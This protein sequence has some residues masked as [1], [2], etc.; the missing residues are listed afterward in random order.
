M[1]CHS[2]IPQT[3][4]HT[5]PVTMTSP[6]ASPSVIRIF[7]DTKSSPTLRYTQP[8]PENVQ[9]YD[10]DPRLVQELTELR[11]LVKELRAQLNAKPVAQPVE[12]V[13]SVLTDVLADMCDN[14]AARVEKDMDTFN[15]QSF[16]KIAIND[17]WEME[18]FRKNYG[19]F[20]PK[21]RTY[22]H[23]RIAPVVKKHVAKVQWRKDEPLRQKAREAQRIRNE[24]EEAERKAR[25][26]L[27]CPDAMH[28]MLNGLERE[29]HKID[30]LCDN[31]HVKEHFKGVVVLE[32]KV[33]GVKTRIEKV[34]PCRVP[35]A[36]QWCDFIKTQRTRVDKAHIFEYKT[37]LNSIEM[38]QRNFNKEAKEIQD[39]ITEGN[40]KVKYNADTM[41]FMAEMSMKESVKKADEVLANLPDT[42]PEEPAPPAPEPEMV[43]HT[44][45]L[46]AQMTQPE[47]NPSPVTTDS[48]PTTPMHLPEYT[49][50]CNTV[51]HLDDIQESAMFEKAKHAI[52]DPHS[53]DSQTLA[54]VHNGFY[55]VSPDKKDNSIITLRKMGQRIIRHYNDLAYLS[56]G[57]YRR[58]RYYV[59]P[60]CEPTSTN[61]CVVNVNQKLNNEL[62]V[63]IF[64]GRVTG[65]RL[66]LTIPNLTT[67][68]DE[69]FD[70][71]RALEKKV[72]IK[73]L[74]ALAAQNLTQA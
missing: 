31:E 13:E 74:D 32:K 11:A 63:G 38:M 3:S 12:D 8:T 64:K 5:M 57:M 25:E 21:N 52:C 51:W 15:K 10:N 68:Q 41:R 40:K 55:M 7:K 19:N 17:L 23:E 4:Q 62:F 42:I 2:Q 22:A 35:F 61:Y 72:A 18:L 50:S 36:K 9:L 65:S 58:V 34:M 59:H 60:S 27:L 24:K 37:V 69:V 6:V 54:P 49:D 30:V 70:I 29:A 73:H 16:R 47:Y 39:A 46:I 43:H 14:G 33:K 71:S 28:A 1:F 44:A 20:L 66:K 45:D 53:W 26:H 56:K 48:E 67:G